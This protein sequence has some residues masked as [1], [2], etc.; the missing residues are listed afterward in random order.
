[1]RGKHN[2]LAAESAAAQPVS[3]HAPLDRLSSGIA[4]G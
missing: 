3:A 2:S 1:M 4:G